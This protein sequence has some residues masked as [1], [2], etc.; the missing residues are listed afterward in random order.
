MPNVDSLHSRPK[1]AKDRKEETSRE[2]EVQRN[3]YRNFTQRNNR[4]IKNV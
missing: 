3:I 4:K 1:T 2:N